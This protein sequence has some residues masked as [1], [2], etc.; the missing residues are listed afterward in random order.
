MGTASSTDHC[1]L[2][3]EEGFEAPL[4]MVHDIKEGDVC[5]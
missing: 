1:E 2:I 4:G 5:D 3:K